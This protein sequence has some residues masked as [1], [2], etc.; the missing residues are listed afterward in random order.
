M[1]SH[2]V[3]LT[4]SSCD[5]PP[6]LLQ[7]AEI[8]VLPLTFTLEGRTYA[9][10][11]DAR[12][13]PIEK[14]YEKLKDGAAAV[15]AA[16]NVAELSDA[17]ESHLK[18][19]EDVLF[20]CFSSALSSTRDSCAIAAQELSEKY[21]DRRIYTVD[22]LAAS[23]GQGLLVYLTARRRQ[24]GATIDEARDY[25]EATKLRVAH[26][27]TVDD[28]H[29]LKRGGRI[30]PAAAMVG[31][32]LNVKPV[33][34]VDDEGRLISMEKVRGRKAAIHRLLEKM[35]EAA[36]DPG[37]QLILIGHTA[38]LPEA[39]GLRDMIEAEFHPKEICITDVGPIIGAHTGPG[40]VT[41]FFLAEH[42]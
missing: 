7:R 4:E 9:H 32:M 14:F 26:W 6:E 2:Y 12:E 40:L 37:S 42:R 19:G 8:E 31:T 34:H 24:E 5:L 36:T 15:T 25:A 3:I 16:A 21:P 27:F 13:Y 10:Y 39:E 28:L 33:L 11:P 22:T 30:S 23:L 20:L 17:M 18:R 38:C 1:S 29:F 35:E 41:L